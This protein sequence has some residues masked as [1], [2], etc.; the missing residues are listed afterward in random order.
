MNLIDILRE[1]GEASAIPYEY[2]Y[3][4]SLK[5]AYFNTDKGTPYKV[6]FGMGVD[7]EMEI[8]FGVVDE[9]DTMNYEIDTNVE[10]A[11]PSI[12]SAIIKSDL[13]A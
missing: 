3:I 9:R 1:V 10:S 11:S 13:F 5:V 6:E 8:S 12:S 4:P 7:K 2:K